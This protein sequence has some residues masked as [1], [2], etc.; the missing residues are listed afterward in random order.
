MKRLSVCSI[1]FCGLL[2]MNPAG[3]AAPPAQGQKPAAGGNAIRLDAQRNPA[4]SKVFP[5][6]S[7]LVYK[8]TWEDRREGNGDQLLSVVLSPGEKNTGW[9]FK[10][11]DDWRTR[12]MYVYNPEASEMKFR[13]AVKKG[14]PGSILVRNVNCC[15]M[16]PEDLQKNLLTNWNFEEESAGIDFWKR[17]P[18]SRNAAQFR[19]AADVNPMNGEQSLEL[20]LPERDQRPAGICCRDIPIVPGRSYIF[21]FWAK[22]SRKMNLHATVS[23]WSPFWPPFDHKKKHSWQARAFKIDE[24]WRPY[25]WKLSIPSDISEYP[26]LKWRMVRIGFSSFKS[27][28][29]GRI[30]LDDI[31]FQEEEDFSVSIRAVWNRKSAENENHP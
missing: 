18:L 17:E 16:T 25:R 2:C 15:M 23:V 9:Q 28:E 31:V 5:V 14:E 7:E 11:T 4:F 8:L 21:S 3:Y 27:A 19:I 24:T 12:T 22:G 26:D 20:F 6:R 29:I 30:W 10:P 1:L 13:I